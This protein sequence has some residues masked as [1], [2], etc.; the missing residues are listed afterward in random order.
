VASTITA[1]SVFHSADHHSFAAVPLE[2]LPWRL[3]R[4]PPGADDLRPLDLAELVSPEDHYRTACVTR[5]SSR[6]W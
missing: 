6:P 4:A 2:L 3:R 5:C 1:V